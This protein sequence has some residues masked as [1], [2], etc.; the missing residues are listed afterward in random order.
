MAIVKPSSWYNADGLPWS[1]GTDEGRHSVVAGYRTDGPD[2]VIEV[3]INEAE[4]FNATD[5]YL[6]SDKV[7]L[8]VGAMIKSVE[9]QPN[10]EAFAS[11]TG[12]ATLSIGVVDDDFASNN[13]I[14]ALLNVA[15]VAQM[16][17]GG[18]AAGDG[19][20]VG[21]APL[22]KR[23]FLTLSV[24]TETL[25][26]GSATVLITYQIPKEKNTDTLVYTK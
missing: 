11:G 22:T 20:L 3:V 2:R 17:A 19:A 10:N 21:G 4:A 16:N 9:V 13:D 8:P 24:D 14:D 15:S 12:A 7:C 25:T 6:I 26:A 18:T 23:Q 5:E 1:F